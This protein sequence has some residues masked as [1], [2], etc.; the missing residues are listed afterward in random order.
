MVEGLLLAAVLVAHGAIHIGFV[1][2]RPP[3]TA[4]GPAWPFAT[5]RS[6]LTRGHHVQPRS[7]RLLALALVPLT[8]A[9]FAL[10][11]VAAIGVVPA[12]WATAI[13]IGSSASLVLLIAFFHPW[14]VIGIGIDAALLWATFVA[15]WTPVTSTVL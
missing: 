14:L 3:A 15:G 8:I 13:A 2:P 9:G 11:A 12:L 1:S 7:A 10:A 6:W 4:D 5:E